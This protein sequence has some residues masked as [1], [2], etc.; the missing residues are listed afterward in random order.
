MVGRERALLGLKRHA[1]ICQCL[2]ASPS[3][4]QQARQRAI[5]ARHL[6]H[7]HTQLKSMS[8][9]TCA[10][11]SVSCA[12][13]PATD[14]FRICQLCDA[15][16]WLRL[17]SQPPPPSPG[18]CLDLFIMS[19][20]SRLIRP[21]AEAAGRILPWGGRGRGHPLGWTAR[22]AAA[23]RQLPICPAPASAPPDSPATAPPGAHVSTRCQRTR[24]LAPIVSARCRRARHLAPMSAPDVSARA[25]D[26]RLTPPMA[27]QP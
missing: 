17:Q 16:H 25:A 13:V 2:P 8:R 12:G 7:P 4:A 23:P 26:L 14:S 18:A 10:P 3:A 9:D 20:I 21:Q 24:H 15:S 1:G 22:D 27:S 19:R 6:A 5:A 11:E